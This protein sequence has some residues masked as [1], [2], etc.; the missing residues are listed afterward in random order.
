MKVRR[1]VTGNDEQGRSLVVSDGLTDYAKREDVWR[2]SPAEPLGDPALPLAAAIDP[3]LGGTR[4]GVVDIPPG[5]DGPVDPRAGFHTTDTVDY[6]MVLEGE[7]TLVLD[8]GSVDLRRGDCVVQRNTAHAWR[9]T[10]SVP[11]TIAAVLV[12][13]GAA[14]DSGGRP[15]S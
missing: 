6:V 9:N 15:P 8:E 3:P 13:L 11:A 4:W 10:G 14:D 1:V 2:T 12:S 5:G 7:L